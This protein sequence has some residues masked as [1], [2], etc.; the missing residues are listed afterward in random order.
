MLSL[1]AGA[2]ITDS[3]KNRWRTLMSVDDVI[4]SLIQT[5]TDLDI[6]DNTCVRT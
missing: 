5:C 1:A 3:F 4:A 2:V 6:M